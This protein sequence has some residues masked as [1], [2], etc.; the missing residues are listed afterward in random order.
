MSEPLAYLITFRTYGTWLHGDERGS[1]DRKN[2]TYK[3][4]L[5]PAN[6]PLQNAE[7]SRLQNAPA[8]LNHE[9]REVIHR[10]IQDVCDHRGWELHELNVRTNHV[11]AVISAG[12]PPEKVMNDFK[13]WATRR[14]RESHL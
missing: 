13:S 11:H 12:N 3:S 9:Q 5:L 1:I 8:V 4:P 10:T 6:G 2:N 7:K 14:L